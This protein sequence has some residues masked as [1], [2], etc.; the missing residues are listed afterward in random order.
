MTQRVEPPKSSPPAKRHPTTWRGSGLRL[1][2]FGVVLGA[3]LFWG[4]TPFFVWQAKRALTAGQPTRALKWLGYLPSD[5]GTPG[6]VSYWLGVAY[7]RADELNTAR[8]YLDRA[9]TL[10]YRPEA[11]ARQKMLLEIQAGNTRQALDKLRSLLRQQWNDNEAEEVYE[12]FAKGNIAHYR[13][14][15]AL[16]CLEYWL[17]WRPHAIVPRLWRADIYERTRNLEQAENE[18]Q[19][20]LAR[21]PRHDEARRKLARLLMLNNK[22]E[23]A[24]EQYQAALRQTPRDPGLRLGLARCYRRLANLPAATAEFSALLEQNLNDTDRAATL[25]ELGQI[26]L[27]QRQ[28]AQAA[29]LLERSVA[30]V[31]HDSTAQLAYSQCLARLGRAD[32][33]KKH[34]ELGREIAARYQRLTDLTEV[35]AREPTKT[36][37]RYKIGMEFI[38]QGMHQ[39]GAHWLSTVLRLDPYHVPTHAALAKYHQERGETELAARH[40]VYSDPP[41]SKP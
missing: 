18:Y 36:E 22:V 34:L 32:Q 38:A 7:R 40:R 41:T 29:K 23:E 39:E 17:Q 12:A 33:A 26:A 8:L 20:V 35:V 3:L 27:E 28:E 11:V 24:L 13:F 5:A 6:E 1:L 2:V 14:S 16:F 10:G 21:L 37:P 15:E 31:P 9:L 25:S 19:T 4:R 30:L